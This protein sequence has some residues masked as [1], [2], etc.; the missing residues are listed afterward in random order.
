MQKEDLVDKNYYPKEVEYQKQIH[1]VNNYELLGEEITATKIESSIIISFPES[2]KTSVKGDILI[3]RPSDASLDINLKIKAD[4]NNQ[5]FIN[6]EKLKP[7]KYIL[8]IDWEC[9]GIGY[10]HEL[11]III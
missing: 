1:K 8:K 5:Q 10:Y 7:G 4:L 11:I 6:T 3:Y 9:E 2:H